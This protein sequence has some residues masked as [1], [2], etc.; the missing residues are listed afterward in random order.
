MRRL[1]WIG[2]GAVTTIVVYRKGRQVY[3]RYV[4]SAVAER[5]QQGARDASGRAGVA[6]A[7]FRTTFSQARAARE[8]ELIAALLAEGQQHPDV[9]RASRKNK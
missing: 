3:Q 6:L 4:P 5:V 1:F 9:T 8:A 7:E 2:V